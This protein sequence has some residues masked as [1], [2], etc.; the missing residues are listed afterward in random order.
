MF[1]DDYPR[2]VGEDDVILRE[3]LFDDGCRRDYK[4]LPS[5]EPEK[6][7]GTMFFGEVVKTSM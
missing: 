5:A 3:A 4:D 2:A 6:Q 1:S 7:Y